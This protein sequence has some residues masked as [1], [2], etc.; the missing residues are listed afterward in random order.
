[1][2]SPDLTPTTAPTS[3]FFRTVFLNKCPYCGQGDFFVSKTAFARNFDKMHSH[4]PTCG[5]SLVPEPGFYQGA[6]YMSYSIYTAFM[7]TYF[8]VFSYF[9]SDYYD[10]FLFILLP[11]FVLITPLAYRLARRS[12]LALFSKPK[13]A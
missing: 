13:T 11:A 6:L 2:T 10:Y 3:S 1:M 12:W 9:F 5:E 4:C 8:L 7:V